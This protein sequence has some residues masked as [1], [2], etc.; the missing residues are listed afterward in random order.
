MVA[1]NEWIVHEHLGPVVIEG[2]GHF[3]NAFGMK[4]GADCLLSIRRA[5]EKQKSAS[6]SA[7]NLPSHGAAVAG[8][9]VEMVNPGIGN[10]PGNALLCPPSLVQQRSEKTEIARLKRTEHAVGQ[11]SHLVEG[12]KGGPGVAMCCLFLFLQYCP[13]MMGGACEEKHQVRLQFTQEFGIKVQRVHFGKAIVVEG[14]EI[15]A[16]EGGCKFVLP[17][18]VVSQDV[19]GNAECTFSEIVFREWPIQIRGQGSE[20][21][22]AY[23][24]GRTQARAG[25]DLR[26]QE[27]IHRNIACQILEYGQRNLEAAAASIHV[28]D[29]PPRFENPQ[30]GGD[31]LNPSVSAFAQDG[32]EI[33]V[34]GS[35]E[36]SATEALII[37][38][39]VGSSSGKANA[40][41]T[42]N[43]EHSLKSHGGRAL[44]SDG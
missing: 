30:V 35:A 15:Q 25:G 38:R 44:Q 32:V 4:R 7:G 9:L 23:T 39:E 19:T 34:D 14:N 21:I 29:I 12:V 33:L 10:L 8:H 27:K 17:A 13:G 40:H 28:G 42:T 11:G 2:K 20:D 31:N 5:V 41:W 24:G 26:G 16:T 37:G 6:T 3:L 43:D 18:D 22:H 1:V 36:H